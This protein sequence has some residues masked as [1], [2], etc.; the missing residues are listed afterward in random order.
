MVHDKA[1]HDGP[2]L[3]RGA[4]LDVVALG[5]DV[6]RSL[7]LLAELLEE[8]ELW[9]GGGV[10]LRLVGVLVSTGEGIDGSV[11]LARTVLHPE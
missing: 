11:E 6:R 9:A 5:H 4:G 1:V 8:G 7:R 2:V 3:V 10:R